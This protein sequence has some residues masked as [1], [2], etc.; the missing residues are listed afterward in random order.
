MA[1]NFKMNERSL[2]AVLLRSPWWI[3]LLI[4]VLISLG[5]FALLS[6]EYA[7]VVML[8]TFPFVVVAAI[9]A[10]RQWRA[11]STARLDAALERAAAMNW[12]D[13][14]AWLEQIYVARGYT[15]ERLG[16]GEAADLRITR[17]GQRSLLSCRR[18]KAANHGVENLR[19]LQAACERE[20]ARGAYLSLGPVSEAA[21]AYAKQQGL[22]LVDGRV[23]GLLLTQAER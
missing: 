15:V 21:E 17:A 1:F 3:S 18:W 20:G 6:R 23:L 13:F 9:A 5:A 11:P 22:E 19:S 7:V 8:G 14:G 4:S 12:R 2:F 10:W 16:D